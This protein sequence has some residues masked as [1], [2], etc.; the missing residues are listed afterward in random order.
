MSSGSDE[1]T[2]GVKGSEGISRDRAMIK[3]ARQSIADAQQ[4]TSDSID[5]LNESR[6]ALERADHGDGSTPRDKGAER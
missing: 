6:D 1:D 3:N 5:R 4:H 2:G